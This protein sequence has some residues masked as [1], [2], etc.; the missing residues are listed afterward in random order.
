[1]NQPTVRETSTA[2]GTASRPCDSRSIRTEFPPVNPLTCQVTAVLLE[3]V[4]VAVN[5]CVP[6]VTSDA[7]VGVIEMPT[8]GGAALTV[9]FADADLVLSAALVAVT[10]NVPALPGAVYMPLEEMLPPLADQ[11]TAVL[12]LPVTVAVN[13]SVAPVTNDA[14][15]GVIE[16]PTTGGAAA[17][18]TLA[19]ADL[20]VSAAL[21]AVTV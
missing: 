17:T 14:E 4:T 6:P 20:V 9:T 18:V 16:M 11:V 3:P 15:V 1:M 2:E 8:T 13:C 5:C 19:E 7:E 10:A 12:L 21:V